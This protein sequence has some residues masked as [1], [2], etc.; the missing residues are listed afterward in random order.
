[1][2]HSETIGLECCPCV[3]CDEDMTCSPRSFCIKHA[4]WLEG[5]KKAMHKELEDLDRRSRLYIQDLQK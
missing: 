2:T 3:T 5:R 1:M 4:V